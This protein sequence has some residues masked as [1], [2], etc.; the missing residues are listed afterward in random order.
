MTYRIPGIVNEVSATF[1]AM[2][3]SRVPSGGGLNAF[4]CASLDNIEYNGNICIGTA[5]EA[6][7]RDNQRPVEEDKFESES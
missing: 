2:T 4:I 5:I 1:V 6:K 7:S 3:T